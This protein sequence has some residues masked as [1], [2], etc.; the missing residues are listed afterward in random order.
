MVG[1]NIGFRATSFFYSLHIQKEIKMYYAH[2]EIYDA[3]I[4][5]YYTY[6]KLKIEHDF[7]KNNS[8]G[9]TTF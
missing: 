6:I 9:L 8:Q 4:E 1:A 5:I 2:I 7:Q 3:H